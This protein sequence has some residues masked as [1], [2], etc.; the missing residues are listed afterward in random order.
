VIEGMETVKQLEKCGSSSGRTNEE[1]LM[2]TTTISV[3]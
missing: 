2:H 3:E 1:L